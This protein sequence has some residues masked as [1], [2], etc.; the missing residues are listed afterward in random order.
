MMKN[1]IAF[2]SITTKPKVVVFDDESI[3]IIFMSPWLLVYPHIFNTTE[4]QLQNQF[5]FHPK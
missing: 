4:I 1:A 2:F 3:T 5:L